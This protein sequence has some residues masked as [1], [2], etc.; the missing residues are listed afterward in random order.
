MPKNST[1]CRT[2][3][4]VEVGLI[5]GIIAQCRVIRKIHSDTFPVIE[6]LKDLREDEDVKWVFRKKTMDKYLKN[7]I[8]KLTN[9]TD[10]VTPAQWVS[11]V[12][13][14]TLEI[15]TLEI[16][17]NILNDKANNDK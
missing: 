15:D 7:K 17:L 4:G 8:N 5:D 10:E 16:E 9:Y 13:E 6:A 12:E 11:L 14:L 1:D 3:P 2:P